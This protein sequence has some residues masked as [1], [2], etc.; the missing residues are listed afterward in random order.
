M[1]EYRKRTCFGSA[2]GKV[3]EVRPDKLSY[4][5]ES[6]GKEMLRSRG[7]LRAEKPTSEGDEGQASGRSG[8]SSSTPDLEPLPLVPLRRLVR[9]KD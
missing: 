2:I 9:L 8:V 5:V 7:M 1:T 3:L 6:S 4:T